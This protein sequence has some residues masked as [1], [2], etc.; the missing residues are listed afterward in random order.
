MNAMKHT[1]N[2]VPTIPNSK[3][4]THHCSKQTDKKKRPTN[5]ERGTPPL[6]KRRKNQES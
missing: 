4:I 5:Q 6:D 1:Y 3:K 2:Y